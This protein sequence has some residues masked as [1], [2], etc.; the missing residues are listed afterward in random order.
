MWLWFKALLLSIIFFTSGCGYTLSHRLKNVF[1]DSQGIFVPIF[2]NNTE[3]LGAE[4]VFT[5]A[6]MR[7]LKVHQSFLIADKKESADLELKGMIEQISYQPTAL[8]SPAGGVNKLQSYVTLPDQ[9]NVVASVR[10]NLINTKTKEILWTRSASASRIVSAFLG[11]TGDKEAA[12][13]FGLFTQSLI[14]SRYSELAR[15]IMRDMYDSM[16]ENL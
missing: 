10:L 6:L 7:E 2:S 8:Y 11:R 15:D 16:L 1:N 4:M 14:D 13:G 3:E 9:L 5:N 12:S